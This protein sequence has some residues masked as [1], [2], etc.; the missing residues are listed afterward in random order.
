M[1]ITA[2]V[3]ERENGACGLNGQLCPEIINTDNQKNI[4]NDVLI[5]CPALCDRSSWTYSLIPIGDQRIKYRGYYIGG[6]DKVT[7]EIDDNQITNP[8]R[9]D[10]YPCGAGVHA[11]VISPFWGGCAR[12]SMKVEN[13]RILK[14][15]KVIME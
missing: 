7:K 1:R 12:M 11:G 14:Q 6:G 5:R 9:A 8:Y 10:S 3:L 13:N 4:E 2:R 15:A